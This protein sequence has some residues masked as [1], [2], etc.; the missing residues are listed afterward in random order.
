MARVLVA[1]SGGVDSAVA[2]L[3]LKRKGHSVAGAYMKTWMNEEGIPLFDCPWIRD[4][5]DARSIANAIGIDFTV[6]NLIDAYRKKVVQ[7]LIEGY[8]NGLT[9]NPDIMCNREIKFG[10]FLEYALAHGFDFVA[11]G[12]YCR[13]RQ[14]ADGS[15]DLLSGVDS[16]KDQS[17]FLALVR[18]EQL[19]KVLFP[20]G[21]MEKA[22]VRQLAREAFLPIAE[23]KD[24]QGIC[25]LGKIKINDF[26]AH[27][28]P[29]RPGAIVTV[30]GRVLGEHQGLH[31]F[32]IG[33]R[34]GICIPSNQDFEKYVVIAKDFSK[35]ELVIAFDQRE[36][37]GLYVEEVSVCG[38]HFIN[39]PLRE[40]CVLWGKPRYRDPFQALHFWP[41]GEGR[42]RVRFEK[43]QRA[44][45]PGQV[46]A[47]Y[48][49]EVLLGGG[50]YL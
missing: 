9:P 29:N 1:L 42:A 43:R 4:V 45:A 48:R 10:V 23:K 2:A 16:N 27:Y 30:E 19:R 47:F 24:S 36:A 28:I 8:Q 50:V 26:L 38:L 25:F 21:E 39:R 5:E 41:E 17:Y 13:K 32:T 44:L 46:L 11:T 6:V 49:G 7:Y 35:N 22:E 3:L 18:Q 15:Y 20:I 31:R 14:N 34:K 12:H 37:P 40:A 33:Q